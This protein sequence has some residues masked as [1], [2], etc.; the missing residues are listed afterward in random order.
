MRARSCIAAALMALAAAA[1][2]ACG[3]CIED[4]VAAVYDSAA[5]ESAVAKHRHVAFLAVDGEIALEPAAQKALVKALEAAGALRGATRVAGENAAVAVV[6]DPKRT[7]LARLVAAGD[8]ALATRHR[9]V[10]ALRI[11]DEGGKLKE[12]A[13]G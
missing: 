12:P 7:T 6:F 11:I 8:R 4:R 3:F 1:A 2:Q 13:A 9:K 5:I 10:T